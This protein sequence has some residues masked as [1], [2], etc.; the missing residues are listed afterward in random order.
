MGPQNVKDLK[1]DRWAPDKPLCEKGQGPPTDRFR[2]VQ[3]I[4][5]QN[6]NGLRNIFLTTDSKCTF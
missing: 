2:D 6:I 3:Y 4:L 5:L 1:E